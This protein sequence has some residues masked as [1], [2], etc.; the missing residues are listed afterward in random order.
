MK[1]L[2]NHAEEPIRLVSEIDPENYEVRKLNF[3]SNGSTGFASSTLSH[4][5]VEL[6]SAPVPSISEIN[7]MEEFEGKEIAQSDFDALWE[8]IVR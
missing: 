5:G 4:L 3:F 8:T 2:H 6:G 1:W 7:E